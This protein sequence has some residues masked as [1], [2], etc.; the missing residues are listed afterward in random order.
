MLDTSKVG[1]YTVTYTYLANPELKVVINIRIAEQ[2]SFLAQCY[3]HGWGYITEN[4]KEIDFGNGR[5]VEKGT[6]I[7]LT[8]VANEGY[9][10][11]GWYFYNEQQGEALISE[12]AT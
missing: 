2:F 10:F 12:D 7:T 9:N 11:L 1:S 8:A 4:G 3:E 5:I 6:A